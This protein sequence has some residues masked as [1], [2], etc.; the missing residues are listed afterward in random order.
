M[1]ELKKSRKRRR[2]KFL[3]NA[4]DEG[5]IIREGKKKENEDIVQSEKR[6]RKGRKDEMETHARGQS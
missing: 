1:Q 6:K 2:T 4:S 5:C 3:N